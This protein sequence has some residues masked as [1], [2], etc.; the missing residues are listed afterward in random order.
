MSAAIRGKTA[1]VGIGSAGVGEARS[2]TAP[3]SEPPA[4]A[5]YR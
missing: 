5:W 4:A 3:T 1:I 2:A